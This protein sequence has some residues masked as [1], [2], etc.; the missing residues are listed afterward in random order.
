MKEYIHLDKI[1]KGVILDDNLLTTKWE[2]RNEKYIFLTNEMSQF[3]DEHPNATLK[4]IFDRKL[5]EKPI[6]LVRQDKLFEI[7]NYDSSDNV[8][9]FYLN[10]VGM[11]LDYSRRLQLKNSL[12]VAES[13][14]KSKYALCVENVGIINIDITL[15][16][17]MLDA[18]ENYATQCYEVTFEHKQNILSSDS[19]EYIENYDY[20][21]NYP[22]KL[23]FNI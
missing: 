17:M 18:I 6:E 21:K 2:E 14:G 1:W 15:C 5:Y 10:D 7:E 19:K 11:W 3:R 13:L 9:E 8:N 20:T 22:E 16:N 4:E 12:S 23:T